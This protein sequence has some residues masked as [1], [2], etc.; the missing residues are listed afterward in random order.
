MN[1]AVSVTPNG[2]AQNEERY[3]MVKGWKRV[4]TDFVKQRPCT[5]LTVALCTLTYVIRVLFRKE[6]SMDALGALSA[7]LVVQKYQIWR[8]VTYCIIHVNVTHLLFNMMALVHLGLVMEVR[9]GP[10]G[11]LKTMGMVSLVGVVLYCLFCYAV[12]FALSQTI[13]KTT[14]TVGFSGILFGLLSIESIR[15]GVSNASK[16]SLYGIVSVPKWAVPWCLLVLI[17]FLVPSSSL[18]GHL[19]GMLSGYIFRVVFFNRDD[20]FVD[21]DWVLGQYVAAA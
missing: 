15:G 2:V 21:E 6:E 4:C 5:S 18:V 3:S 7:Y 19:S 13:Y 20:D 8:A 1:E 17:F 9:M 10:V 12:D 14:L 16:V 11:F